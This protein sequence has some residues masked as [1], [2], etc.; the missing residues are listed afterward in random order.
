MGAPGK[1]SVSGSHHQRMGDGARCGISPSLRHWHPSS[2]AHSQPQTAGNS[3][4]FSGTGF[5]PLP[6]PRSERPSSAS[7]A[8]SVG[9]V[10]GQRPSGP[11]TMA[12]PVA[13]TAQPPGQLHPLS[14]RSAE[15]LPVEAWGPFPGALPS[16]S[17][18]AAATQPGS[19]R[20]DGGTTGGISIEI[21]TWL[22]G[23]K[24]VWWRGDQST[25]SVLRCSSLAQLRT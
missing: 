24:G 23:P 16:C 22:G 17:L 18:Q 6:P 25:P 21:G 4:K 8:A 15:V 3:Q 11:P 19:A 12:V 20:R 10:V 13:G 2:S 7:A 14:L 1:T 5:L 9:W